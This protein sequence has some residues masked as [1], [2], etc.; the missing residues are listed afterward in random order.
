MQTTT[1]TKLVCTPGFAAGRKQT[2]LL[3]NRPSSYLLHPRR[4]SVSSKKTVV[5]IVINNNNI[6]NNASFSSSRMVPRSAL[7][8]GRTILSRATGDDRDTSPLE[9][10]VL[11]NNVLPAVLVACLGSFLFGYHLGIVN[12][13]LNAI[14]SSLDIAT[15]ASLKSAIVSI[16]L[17]FAAVGSVLTGPLADTLGRRSSLTFCAAPL[18][19]GPAMCAQANSIG[20]MLVGRA[21]SGLGVGI[22]SNLVPLYVTEISPEKFRGTLGSLVQLSICVGILVAVLL[23][24]PYDP[25]FPALQESMSFLK[26]NFETWWRSMFYVAGMPALLMG[27]AGKVIPESPKWLRSR[28]K[29]DEAVKAENLLWGGV[30]STAAQDDTSKIEESEALLKSESATANWIEALFDPRYRKGVWIGALLFFAQQFAGINAVIYFSTPLFAAA[31]LRNAVLGSV[32]VS[33]VNIGGTLVSTKVLD[34]SGRK[35]LLQKSFLGMGACCVFLSLAALNPT[36][37][38]SSYVSL[39]GTLLYI[40]AFGFGVGPIPGLLASELNSERVRG[41]A[42]SF[43]FLSHWFFNFCI[44]QGFLPVVEKVGISLVWSF[45]AAVCFISSALTQKYIIETKGKSFAEIEKEMGTGKVF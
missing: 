39:F 27:F 32:A 7:F 20:E 9:G 30:E 41:K 40:F 34:K 11:F 16:I 29:I 13:A 19:V 6:N 31:G 28:G 45:F 15:N 17:A 12:P 42:M 24:I 43:A 37:T 36:L 5:K 10:K 1:T 18:L 44:G 26:F 8:R 2:S 3:L 4:I 38:I 25:S 22:A 23:G 14:S 35:P 33:A 21:I